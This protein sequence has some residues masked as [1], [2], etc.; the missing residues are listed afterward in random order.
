MLGLMS[1]GACLTICA[2]TLLLVVGCCEKL[3][4]DAEALRDKHEKCADGDECV[5]VDMYEAAGE[6]NC[7]GPFQCSHALN[8]KNLSKFES[9]AR[10]IADDYESCNECTKGK[11]ASYDEATHQAV[12]NTQT[13]KCEVQETQGP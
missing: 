10:E 4:E 12:C 1:K 7:L 6:N 8:A 13:G 9:D 2:L 11:C 3:R 5:V